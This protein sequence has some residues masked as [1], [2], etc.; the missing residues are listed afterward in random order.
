M[1]AKQ[2]ALSLAAELWQ[3][4]SWRENG[5]GFTSRFARLRIRPATQAEH[6]D[7][8]WLPIEW[9]EDEAEPTNYWLSTLPADTSFEVLIDRAELR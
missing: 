2:L 5:E 7:N 8:E 6:P 9:P 4:I 3:M 1:S